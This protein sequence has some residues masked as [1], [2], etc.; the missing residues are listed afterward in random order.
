M[1]LTCTKPLRGLSETGAGNRLGTDPTSQHRNDTTARSCR[2]NWA[3]APDT[4]SYDWMDQHVP[5]PLAI[6]TD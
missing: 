6:E 4:T 1:I 3:W 5:L 2:S